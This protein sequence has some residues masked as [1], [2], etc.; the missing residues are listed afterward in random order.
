MAARVFHLCKRS[1]GWYG[2]SSG[3]YGILDGSSSGGI[4][5]RVAGGRLFGFQGRLIHF[6]FHFHDS[7]RIDGNDQVV[8]L[9]DGNHTALFGG[10]QFLLLFFRVVATA[11]ALTTAVAAGVVAVTALVLV[12]RRRQ[13]C[14]CLLLLSLQ[15]A[16]VGGHLCIVDD[17]LLWSAAAAAAA[18]ERH[19][20]RDRSSGGVTAVF[21]AGETRR[22]TDIGRMRTEGR[23]LLLLSKRMFVSMEQSGRVDVAIL[24][25]RRVLLLSKRMLALMEQSGRVDV[26]ILWR[27]RVMW[28]LLLLQESWRVK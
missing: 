16:A 21:A 27:R 13:H 14:A 25:R 10:W 5:A 17:R 9:R 22:I 6:L 19:R 8:I 1:S 2:S 3:W 12:G 11:S 20:V 18:A 23:V 28:Q 15:I 24:G 26:A 7:L 4:C